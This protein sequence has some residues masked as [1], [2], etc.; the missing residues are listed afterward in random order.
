MGQR[1]SLTK[2]L[3][4]SNVRSP[5]ALWNATLIRLSQGRSQSH[6]HSKT[7]SRGQSKKVAQVAQSMDQIGEEENGSDVAA[8]FVEVMHDDDQ[9]M[10]R[11]VDEQMKSSKRA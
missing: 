3:L 10:C 2:K 5:K 6:S 11:C 4:P 7:Y 8:G 9:K 1:M